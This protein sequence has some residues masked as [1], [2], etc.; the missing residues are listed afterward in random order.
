MTVREYIGARYVPLFIG[1]WSNTV[2]YEPLSIVSYQGNSYTSRQAVPIGVNITDATYWV[3]SADFNA[4][5]DA[6][7]R[8]VLAVSSALPLSD[9]SDSNTV[10]KYIDDTFEQ[11][12]IPFPTVADM[13]SADLSNGTICETLGFN[14]VG[15]CGAAVYLISS[16]GTD[17]GK[18][19][20]A[21]DNTMHAHLVIVDDFIVPE[22]LG[23]TADGV[24]DDTAIIQYAID[25]FKHV[26]L[27]AGKSYAITALE[28]DT[29]D[30]LDGNGAKLIQDRTET[31]SA[32]SLKSEYAARMTVKNIT[33][34]EG[35]T[36]SEYNSATYIA[37]YAI[38]FNGSTNVPD[39]E[40]YNEDEF[41]DMAAHIDNVYIERYSG[42]G[43]RVKGRGLSYVNRIEV[44]KCRGKGILIECYD[45][46]FTNL[47][48][49]ICD[50]NGIE[51]T[52]NAG[53]NRISNSKAWGCGY[54]Y[55]T[56][57]YGWKIEGKNIN[58]SNCE[59]QDNYNAG[60]YLAGNGN[61]GDGLLADSNGTMIDADT[62]NPA[63]TGN[64]VYNFYIVKDWVIN[65][66][67][68]ERSSTLSPTGSVYLNTDATGISGNISCRL[69]S[70]TS[71]IPWQVIVGNIFN[72]IMNY[73]RKTNVS[74][75]VI[76]GTDS[77]TILPLG[78]IK[79]VI[80][81]LGSYNVEAIVNPGTDTRYYIGGGSEY[82]AIKWN[83][84]TGLFEVTKSNGSGNVYLYTI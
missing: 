71:V 40:D 77:T 20:I 53:N 7:R 22:M 31:N 2:S 68:V 79:A 58:L 37:K 47:E 57:A 81:G 48:I 5:V 83:E 1:E 65:G 8:E 13:V 52:N 50:G 35:R 10:R 15:D 54:F 25:T 64:A 26:K 55:R 24:T 84:S 56:N 49:G 27:S 16:T 36:N 3:V 60:F 51:I 19:V 75:A 29:L 61:I 74:I 23:A 11:C 44:W 73:K 70:D 46:I 80:T 9:F 34:S 38:D 30:V 33:I 59:A 39:M 72:V 6:Y 82:A 45:S 17:N 14:S 69:T 4:Q 63:P 66:K 28:L 62:G 21:L 32:I 12:V 67:S 41:V 76:A 78:P 42:N 18:D 43:V